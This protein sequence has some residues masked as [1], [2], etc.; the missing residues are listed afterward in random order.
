MA[1]VDTM[2]VYVI[3]WVSVHKVTQ[4]LHHQTYLPSNLAVAQIVS[5]RVRVGQVIDVVLGPDPV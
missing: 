1:P 4:E 5:S 2:L 3:P